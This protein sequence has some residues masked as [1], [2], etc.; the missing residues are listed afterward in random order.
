MKKNYISNSSESIKLFSNGIMESLSKIHF[1]VPLFIYIPVIIIFS[2]LSFEN[3]IILTAF[4][5]Y[6]FLGITV[7]TVTEY[8]LHRYIFHFYPTSEWGKRIH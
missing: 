2:V 1:S 4:M 6:L 3:N 7:W 8:I 5:G